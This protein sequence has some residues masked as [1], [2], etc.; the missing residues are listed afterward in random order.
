MT[1]NLEQLRVDFAADGNSSAIT[2]RGG[3]GHM[4]VEGSFGGGTLKL[5]WLYRDVTYIEVGT[6]TNMTAAGASIFT[7]PE[8]VTLRLELT[9]SAGPAIKATLL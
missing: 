9:G 5:K 8:G 1:A 3:E 7:L 4:L 6:N 2:W